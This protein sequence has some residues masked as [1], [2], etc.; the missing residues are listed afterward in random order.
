MVSAVST[1]SQSI[2]INGYGSSTSNSLYIWYSGSPQST[3][4][5]VQLW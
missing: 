4:E 2:G 5:D 3:G 1:P